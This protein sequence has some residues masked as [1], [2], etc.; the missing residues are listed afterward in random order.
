MNIKKQLNIKPEYFDEN[1]LYYIIFGLYIYKIKHNSYIDNEKEILIPPSHIEE[2]KHLNKSD[3]N[4]YDYSTTLLNADKN[5]KD[6]EIII[7][8]RNDKYKKIVTIDSDDL[9]NKLKQYLFSEKI[10]VSNG[11]ILMY[12][13]SNN[14]SCGLLENNQIKLYIC[15]KFDS[16][17][18]TLIKKTS[19]IILTQSDSYI[20]F[21]QKQ[22]LLKFDLKN[23]GI[24]GL[25]KEIDIIIRRAI[26]SRSLS[27]ETI[28]DLNIKHIKG[29]LLYGPP[30]CGKT[31]IAR[32]ISKCLNC[33]KP[34]IINGPEIMKKYI[35]ESEETM[36]NLFKDAYEDHKKYGNKSPLH[37][38]IFDELDAICR[39]RSD[40][41][42]VSALVNDKIVT[43]LLTLM[44]GIEQPNNFLIIGITNRI[45]L[46]DD[47][48]K[49]PGRFEIQIKID[50]PDEDGRIE[51]LEKKT[52]K[53]FDKEKIDEKVDL[54]M[55][56][57][58][59]NNYSG[60][61]L[62][63]LVNSAISFAINR[64]TIIN[65]SIKIDESKILVI[66]DD[67][68]LAISEA[69]P[70]FGPDQ[71]ILKQKSE[72]G[73]MMYSQ[74]FKILYDEILS[75]INKWMKSKN[76]QHVMSISGPI[77]SGRT[78]LMIH[79]AQSIGYQMIKYLSEFSLSHMDDFKKIEYI[80]EI[81]NDMDKTQQSV[82]LID[83]FDNIINF[84]DDNDEYKYNRYICTFINSLLSDMSKNKRLIIFTFK[85]DM[86]KYLHQLIPNIYKIY[87]IG[88][89]SIDP[90]IQD[91]IDSINNNLTDRT[92]YIDIDSTLPIKHYIINYNLS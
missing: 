60:A 26:L 19:S 87:D 33:T 22:K 58:M 10:F 41:S 88:K 20:K 36:R 52:Q 44:D 82:L 67:F 86:S 72:Y 14:I 57:K 51:I 34:I 79:I 65:D 61:E 55:I 9:I 21:I 39:K 59:T 23:S 89:N 8:L 66:M 69:I 73:I 50:L 62:E 75:D 32:N 91:I 80:K 84:I 37:L 11:Q 78:N 3:I 6:I 2:I 56:A 42:H 5:I 45:E 29:I 83:N 85:S 68:N 28:Y 48:L 40:E 4:I 53:L 46:I 77:G 54:S 35:G 38:I 81:V 27:Q 71:M 74:K 90:M 17:K 63:G 70:K 92:K 43:Q 30:G 47:A 12:N 7:S 76:K 25:D 31:L 64:Q 16:K 15:F 1:E 18:Y 24:G 49:R 13:Y